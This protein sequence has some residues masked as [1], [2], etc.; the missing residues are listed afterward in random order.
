MM[1]NCID[2]FK[3]YKHCWHRFIVLMHSSSDFFY[4]LLS[5]NS[6]PFLHPSPPPYCLPHPNSSVVYHALSGWGIT[7]HGRLTGWPC[8]ALPGIHDAAR[9]IQ[10][11]WLAMETSA[12]LITKLMYINP[13]NSIQ[14]WRAEMIYCLCVCLCVCVW[15]SVCIPVQVQNSVQFLWQLFNNSYIIK[16]IWMNSHSKGVG[17]S[18]AEQ[19]TR[20]RKEDAFKSK[21]G[22]SLDPMILIHTDGHNHIHNHMHTCFHDRLRRVD[23][24]PFQKFS[25]VDQKYFSFSYNRNFLMSYVMQSISHRCVISTP[26]NVCRYY[27]HLAI[28]WANVIG[29]CD[30]GMVFPKTWT[31]LPLSKPIIL[32]VIVVISCC[33]AANRF[34]EQ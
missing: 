29:I 27:L 8:P 5:Y 1:E 4:T 31:A 32:Q 26:D 3:C 20:R 15:V 16:V 21:F 7:S 33:K 25:E 22:L 19:H 13:T 2:N 24:E 10:L 11:A 28:P 6:I 18:Y 23:L 12:I 30:V 17:S 14:L 34:T 9:L